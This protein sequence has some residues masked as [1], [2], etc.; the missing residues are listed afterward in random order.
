MKTKQLGNS[1]LNVSVVGVGCMMF[2][3]MCDQDTT[4]AVIDA[5][6]E[7]GVNFFDTAD[8]YGAPPGTSEQFVAKALGDRRKDIILTTK[9]GA[10]SG[11]RGGSRR[12]RARASATPGSPAAPPTR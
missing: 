4:T 7:E 10:Q 6:I 8:I 5:A 3:S 9:F 11:G 12:Q 1:D 2:G